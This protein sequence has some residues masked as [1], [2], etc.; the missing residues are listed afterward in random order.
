MNKW[1]F[2]LPMGAVLLA[3]CAATRVSKVTGGPEWTMKGSGAFKDAGA[4]VFYGVGVADPTI[5]ST[6]LKRDAAD[7][8]ARADLQKVFNTYTASLMKDYQGT[9]GQLVE[10]AIETGDGTLYALAK[11]DLEQFKKAMELAKE[12]DSAAKQY[13]RQRSDA[14]FEELAKEE[15]KH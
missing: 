15:N 8:R 7:N 4:N 13:V 10:Q 3:A 5:K 2:V 12:M 1:N 6:S 11:L 9:D 14:L